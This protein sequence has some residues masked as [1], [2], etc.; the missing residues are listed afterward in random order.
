MRVPAKHIF[1]RFESDS[2]LQMP[3]PMVFRPRGFYPP[4]NGSIPLRGSNFYYVS[5]MEPQ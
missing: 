3:R 5:V 1:R 4:V 2:V